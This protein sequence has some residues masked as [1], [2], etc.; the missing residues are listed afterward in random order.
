MKAKRLILTVILGA[1][2]AACGLSSAEWKTFRSEGGDFTISAPDTLQESA[3]LSD[4]QVG[5]I[6]TH[7]FTL[8]HGKD[9]Y[10]V[11]YVDYPI[12]GIAQANPMGQLDGQVLT[13][14]EANN[15]TLVAQKDI[16][17]DDVPGIEFRAKLP[18]RDDSL[19]VRMVYGR[20]YLLD[21]RVYQLLL[22]AGN[23]RVAAANSQ[24]FLASFHWIKTLS[25]Q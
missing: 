21:A 12:P 9:F 8:D 3:T 2:L 24:K 7:I 17:L 18:G 10:L 4:L 16:M 13:I 25:E 6:E 22:V 19:P 23:D 5:Q 11:G 20:V 1:L 15:A 14:L